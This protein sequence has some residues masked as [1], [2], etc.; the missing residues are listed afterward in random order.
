MITVRIFRSAI[1]VHLS[2]CL[3]LLRSTPPEPGYLLLFNGE[4]TE[5]TEEMVELK[6]KFL[7]LRLKGSDELWGRFKFERGKIVYDIEGNSFPV[8]YVRETQFVFIR[9]EDYPQ[10]FLL[11]TGKKADASLTARYIGKLIGR[12]TQNPIRKVYITGE[13]IRKFLSMNPYRPKYSLM[14]TLV[15]GWRTLGISGENIERPPV[16]KTLEQLTSDV[17]AI[18]VYLFEYSWTVRINKD[19]TVVCFQNPPIESFVSFIKTKILPL[20]Y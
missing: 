17:A 8:K 19:G 18:A 7:D 11:V 5:M 16:Y 6:R 9:K 20:L 3:E 14:P 13:M 15:P 2:E 1:S 10:L 4:I 12:G